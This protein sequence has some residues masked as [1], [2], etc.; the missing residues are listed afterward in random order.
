MSTT[1]RIYRRTAAGLKV[2]ESLTSGLPVPH[3]R[4]LGVLQVE[5]HSDMLRAAL[6][7]YSER[8]LAGWLAELARLGYVESVP[9]MSRHDLDFT[10]SLSLASLGT[11]H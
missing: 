2:W 1:D 10:G 9:A 11:R 3:R 7:C 5:A 8:Q 6:S 4:I